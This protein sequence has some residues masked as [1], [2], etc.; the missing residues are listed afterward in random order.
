VTVV[1]VIISG[2]TSLCWWVVKVTVPLPPRVRQ[3]GT[4]HSPDRRRGLDAWFDRLGLTSDVTLAIHDWGSAPGFDWAHRHPGAVR[5]IA[6]ME[7]IGSALA[8]WY[9]KP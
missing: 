1:L 7:A 6:Y 9:R 8:D 4:S 5:G 3:G 2:E